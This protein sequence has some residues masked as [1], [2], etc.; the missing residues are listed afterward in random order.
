MTKIL[1]SV[2]GLVLIAHSSLAQEEEKPAATIAEN[3]RDTSPDG[4]FALRTKYDKTL[5]DRMLNANN[6]KPDNNIFS[7]TI[8]MIDLISLPENEVVA[9]LFD[10]AKEGNNF[11]VTLLWSSDSKWC[12]FYLSY[13]RTGTPP[14]TTC[15]G[16]R[17]KPPTNPK[18][19]ACPPKGRCGTN[20]S[21]QSAG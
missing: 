1:P 2:I 16:K 5:N 15:V 21:S 7:E 19:S 4:K 17:L 18:S 14:S 20:T 6:R 9:T 3:V 8:S 10:A 13:P 11:G 12:A